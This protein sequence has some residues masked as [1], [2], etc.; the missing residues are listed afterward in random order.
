MRKS[1]SKSP[2]RHLSR[3]AH[4]D[5]AV[6]LRIEQV[7]E[8]D[9]AVAVGAAPLGLGGGRAAEDVIKGLGR[10]LLELNPI[11]REPF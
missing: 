2:K 3:G 11:S 10:V 6:V 8:G 1:L 7:G 9:G 4:I 5:G